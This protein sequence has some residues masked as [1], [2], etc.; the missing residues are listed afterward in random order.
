MIKVRIYK[1]FY[2]W[3]QKSHFVNMGINSLYK[4]IKEHAP[5]QI[6]TLDFEEIRGYRVAVDISIFFYKYV[7]TAKEQ[8]LDL[9]LSLLITLKK[10]GIKTVAIFDGPNPPIEK[11]EEQQ[12]RREQ[13]QK[14]KDKMERATNLR[15]EL[16]EQLGPFGQDG[17]ITEAQ[18]V[19]AKELLV[20]KNK[21]DNTIYD[22]CNDVVQALNAE[23][24]KLDR[25]TQRITEEYKL[26]AKEITDIMGI[27]QMEADGE[28]EGLCSYLC[29]TGQVDAVLTEDTDVLAHG[30]PLMLAFKDFKLSE[31]KIYAIHHD[32]LMEALELDEDEFRDL[33]ILL[34]CDYNRHSKTAEVKGYPPDGKKRKKPVGIGPKG[35]WSMIQEYRRLE[36]VEKYMINAELLKYQRCREL[37]TPPTSIPYAIVPYNRRPDKE[38]LLEFLERNSVRLP[39]DIILRE[40]K[41]AEVEFESSTSEG[42]DEGDFK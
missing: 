36:E 1:Q 33:C 6:I 18:K 8:W 37:F 20:K 17:T 2:S 10:F 31:E 3:K 29:K 5:E 16:H 28:A 32:S 40:W 12:H 11:K 38:R 9:F 35:A 30:A 26:I 19:R 41:D 13:T 27:A 22:D 39:V 25:Q 7:L 21:K 34:G 24:E 4:I 23:V 15:D 14:A 42:S